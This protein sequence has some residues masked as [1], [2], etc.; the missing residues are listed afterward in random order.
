M[1]NSAEVIDLDEQRKVGLLFY[2]EGGKRMC[3]TPG[4]T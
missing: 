2:N 4:I 1:I 3:V